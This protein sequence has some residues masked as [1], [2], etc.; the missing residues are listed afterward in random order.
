M[1]ILYVIINVS[2]HCVNTTFSSMY[3]LYF[4]HLCPLLLCPFMTYSGLVYVLYTCIIIVRYYCVNSCQIFWFV[5]YYIFHS[6]LVSLMYHTFV[7]IHA[8][9][10]VME[11]SYGHID[12]YNMGTPSGRVPWICH[13]SLLA[14]PVRIVGLWLLLLRKLTYCGKVMPYCNIDMDQ[15]RLR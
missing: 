13:M 7:P 14:W 3:I 4:Y 11:H 1:C 8:G 5:L 12:T 10:I 6:V 15:H 9:Q 2:N